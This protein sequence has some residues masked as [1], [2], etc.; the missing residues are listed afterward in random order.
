V[1]ACRFACVQER[2]GN[3][4][5]T[6]WHFHMQLLLPQSTLNIIVTCVLMYFQHEK[7]SADM[8]EYLINENDLRPAFEQNGLGDRD[9]QFIKEL[10]YCEGERDAEQVNVFLTA[11]SEKFSDFFG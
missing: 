6:P 7:A 2:S 1:A 9:I 3:S 11:S 5:V 8:F 10:I 4:R